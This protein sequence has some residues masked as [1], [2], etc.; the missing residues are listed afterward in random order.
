MWTDSNLIHHGLARPVI[1]SDASALHWQCQSHQF[2]T[3]LV[4]CENF[5]TSGIRTHAVND[6][7]VYVSDYH[8][9]C[10]TP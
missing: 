2:R 4:T 7:P 8:I 9:T 1:A 3:N 5:G 6:P 10:V